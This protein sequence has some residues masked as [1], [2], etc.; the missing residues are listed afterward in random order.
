IYLLIPQSIHPPIHSPPQTPIYLH[1]SPFHIA[2]AATS[3]SAPP[4]SPSSPHPWPPR[5]LPHYIA[6][7][8]PSLPHRIATPS[9]LPSLTLHPYLNLR[10]NPSDPPS[11]WRHAS[12]P[13][14]AKDSVRLVKH[15]DKPYRKEI[16]KVPAQTTI[17]FVVMGFAG[18]FVKL[19]FIPIN[20]IIIEHS[21]SD[22][23]RVSDLVHDRD[24]DG[25]LLC[26]PV[27]IP[28]TPS[29]SP[30]RPAEVLIGTPLAL[31]LLAAAAGRLSLLCPLPVQLAD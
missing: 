12:F 28:P 17:G 20:N 27:R 19:I 2:T 8:T 15:C 14:F 3:S 7:Q 6:T 11:P 26:S 30:G 4:V 5:A 21:F 24:R 18:F 9:H 25:S 23:V 10:L 16:T 31:R 22:L 13:E 29:S 1:P